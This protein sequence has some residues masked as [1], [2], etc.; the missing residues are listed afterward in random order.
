[1]D[2]INKMD[3]IDIINKNFLILFKNSFDKIEIT[4]DIIEIYKWDNMCNIFN[5]MYSKLEKT[6]NKNEFI[7][8]YYL[9]YLT[10]LNY[11]NFLKFSEHPDYELN[12]IYNF[13]NKIINNFDIIKFIFNNNN[14][15]NYNNIFKTLNPFISN[16]LENNKNIQDIE[17]KKF[18]MNVQQFEK[19]YLG[20]GDNYKKILN[21]ILYRFIL[22]KNVNENNFHDFFINKIIEDKMSYNFDMNVFMEHLPNFK[23]II[24]YNVSQDVKNNLNINLTTLIKFLIKNNENITANITHTN[25]EL[26]NVKFGGKIIFEKSKKKIDNL[27]LFQ[28]NINLISFNVN[29]LKNFS[30]LKKTN[31]FIKI[32]YS[33]SIINNL[34]RLL[35]LTHLITCSVKLLES[36]PSSIYECLYPLDYNKYFYNT[37]VNFLTFIKENINIDM[38]YNRFL[39][40]LIK[41]LYIYSYYDYYFYYNTNLISTIIDRIKYKSDI[42]ND[43]C[44]SLKNIFKLPNEMTNYPPFFNIDDNIDNLIYYTFEIPNYFKFMDLIDAIITVFDIK[45]INHSTFDLYKIISVFKCE[46]SDLFVNQ[47]DIKNQIKQQN[48]N[49]PKNIKKNDTNAYLE[50]NTE[51][52]DNY[53]LETENI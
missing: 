27:N 31:N 35:Y 2:N 45:N 33:S 16:K 14:D 8:N 5:S 47:Q 49:K 19:I 12:D 29:E 3:I 4:N 48:I 1:M 44:T 30:F 26:L 46:I 6:K 51:N 22:S 11:T 38:S 36:Y 17:L 50:I 21:I 34:S 43:F 13:L 15:E 23:G 24:N 52:P 53:A 39:I 9:I 25:I 42:F 10:Y 37:F 18:I 7:T 20:D 41:Y 28:Q 32:E 40:D